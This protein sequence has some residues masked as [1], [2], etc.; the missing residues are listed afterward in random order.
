VRRRGAG[1]PLVLSLPAVSRSALDA[2]STSSI[3]SA[4]ATASAVFRFRLFSS[5]GRTAIGSIFPSPSFRHGQ[6]RSRTSSPSR[7][8]PRYRFGRYRG[9]SRD[10]RI[11]TARH[12]LALQRTRFRLCGI[13]VALVQSVEQGRSPVVVR[14]ETPTSAWRRE[15][16]PRCWRS[17]TDDC[18]YACGEPHGSDAGVRV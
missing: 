2:R 13:P 3:R 4:R 1:S 16:P 15:A 5:I 14:P 8:S 18:G 10:M 7:H 11:H 9:D 6:Q 12:D 17:W